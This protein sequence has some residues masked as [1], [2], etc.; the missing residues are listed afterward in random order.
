VTDTTAEVVLYGGKV[1]TTYYFSTSGGKTASAADVF[2][3]TVPYLVSR[4]DP[5]DKASPYHRWG[6]VLIGARTVQS[7]LEIADRVIDAKGVVTPSGRLR[8]LV[9]ATTGDSEQVPA[10][11]VRT[12]LGL[13]ST[14]VSIGVLRLDRPR[15]SPVVFGSSTRLSGIGRGL[16]TPALTSSADGASWSQVVTVAPDAAGAVSFDVT[17]TRTTRYRLEAEGGASPALLVQVAPRL[18]L[19]RPTQVEPTVLAGTVRPKLPGSVVAIERRKGL[20]WVT[21]GEAAVD[22][23]GAFRLEL[24]AL[25][26]AGSYRARISA[27]STLAGGTSSVVQVP[28]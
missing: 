17:P 4:P 7:K 21:V 10:T 2:G 15:G 9:V 20:A 11:L 3:F 16:G 26:P 22:G 13:R 28:A 1:A 18:T 23:S 27:T 24:D 12:S 19:A 5:W 25:V 14:W 8:A 6:P